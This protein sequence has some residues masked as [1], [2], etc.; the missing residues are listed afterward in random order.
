MVHLVAQHNM[1]DEIMKMNTTELH[2]ARTLYA[3]VS[4]A[5]KASHLSSKERGLLTGRLAHAKKVLKH[6]HAQ[7]VDQV[8]E[9]VAGVTIELSPTTP[10]SE[11]RELRHASLHFYATPRSQQAA[12]LADRVCTQ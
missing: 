9:Q 12:V 6:A 7:V 3:N 2:I 8:T 11:E 5:L 4:K 1:K 10:E